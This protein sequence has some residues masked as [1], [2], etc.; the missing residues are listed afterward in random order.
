MPAEDTDENMAQRVYS[1][2]VFLKVLSWMGQ[3]Q[4]DRQTLVTVGDSR[5][6][7]EALCY[8]RKPYNFGG[9]NS[10]HNL[11]ITRTHWASLMS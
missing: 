2:P 1:V 8:Q 5:L 3:S 7:P 9:L 11:R 6:G 10:K 4:R